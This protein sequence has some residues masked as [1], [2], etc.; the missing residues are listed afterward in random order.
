M[1]GVPY[2]DS[3]NRNW[4]F[5][6][7]AVFPGAAGISMSSLSLKECTPP[8]RRKVPSVMTW[9]YRSWKVPS[10]WGFLHNPEAGSHSG[11]SVT[12]EWKA[13]HRMS[14]SI[15]D[16]IKDQEK[17]T[18]FVSYSLKCLHAV[19]DSLFGFVQ[20]PKDSLSRAG[21]QEASEVNRLLSSLSLW[22]VLPPFWR[23]PLTW[24]GNSTDFSVSCCCH[25]NASS[26]S[27]YTAV[28]LIHLLLCEVQRCLPA[29]YLWAM[30]WLE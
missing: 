11:L 16:W 6:Y 5:T 20:W 30:C 4:S 10:K 8:G 28:G 3:K 21:A 29:L 27:L 15:N 19:K 22:W 18:C 12:L 1:A 25:L 7:W 13:G 14:L 2:T 23:E 17:K 24:S 26:W 9:H